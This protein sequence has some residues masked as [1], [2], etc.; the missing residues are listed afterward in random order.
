MP[1]VDEPNN[2][3]KNEIEEILEHD[4]RRKPDLVRISRP[5]PPPKVRTGTPAWYP[6]PEKLIVG[7]MLLLIAGVAVRRFVLPLTIIGFALSGIGYYLLIRR[8]RR[9]SAGYG[10]GRS[11]SQQTKF[12]RGKPVDSKRPP[13]TRRDGNILEFPGSPR[14]KTRRWFGK[15]P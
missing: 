10:T 2:K 15:K 6:T 1:K 12:W 3:W 5:V 8:N 9:A 7:G 11:N 14:K 4:E 13:V